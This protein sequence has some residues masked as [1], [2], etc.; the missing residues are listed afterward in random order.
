MIKFNMFILGDASKPVGIKDMQSCL[1]VCSENE[2]TSG[3]LGGH[4]RMLS[5]PT[6]LDQPAEVYRS[7]EGFGKVVDVVYRERK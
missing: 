1:I 2:T 4:V 5:I 7:Y 6:S 3:E